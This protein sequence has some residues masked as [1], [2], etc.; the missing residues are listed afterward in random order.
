M[1]EIERITLALPDLPDVDEHPSVNR[2]PDSRHNVLLHHRVEACTGIWHVITRR[3]L[4]IELPEADNAWSYETAIFPEHT[5]N[6][7][8]LAY[9]R[10]TRYG[11]RRAAVS[12]HAHTIDRLLQEQAMA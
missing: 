1:Q 9:G 12:G 7:P 2:L 5:L 11:T 4:D 10:Y 8:D 3:L 6:Q